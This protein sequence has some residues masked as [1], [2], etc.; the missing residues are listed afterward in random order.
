MEVTQLP[1]LNASLNAVATVLL[2]VGVR[3][4]RRG[5]ETAHK[6]TMLAC[7]G[8]SIAFLVSYCIYHL[9][10]GQT[11]FPTYPPLW[12]RLVYFLILF[13]HVVLAAVVPILA[14]V[15]IVLGLLDKRL[16]HRRVAKITYPIWLYVSVTGVLVYLA[17]YQIFPPR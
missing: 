12:I 1:R 17:L 4:I 3:F 5:R 7:F 2:L 9:N 6:R 11:S 10:A 13:S 14:V 16:L 15:T 8:V